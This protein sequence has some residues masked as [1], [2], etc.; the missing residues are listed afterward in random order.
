MID[1]KYAIGFTH[2]ALTDEQKQR[3][4]AKGGQVLHLPVVIC[5]VVPI[6]HVKELKDKPPLKFTG[7]VLAD[8]FRGKIDTWND[9]ALK[10]LNEGIDLPDRKITVVHR[11]DSSGT[12][13]IFTDYLC[14]ES[15]AWRKEVGPPSNKVKWPVGQ[16]KNRN[17]GVAD[18]IYRTEGTIGYVDL[19]LAG[20]GNLQYG[21][22]QNKD[23]SA[24]IH[25]EAD[26]MTAALKGQLGDIPEDLTFRL[27]NQQGK[28]AYPICGC[29]W[30]VCYQAQP[31][32]NQ[33]MVVDFLNW[34]THD[35]QRFAED[36]SYAPLPEELVKR[37]DE[38]LK[39]ITAIQ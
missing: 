21:A 35:V 39:T 7:E 6:Y 34:I 17:H 36:M 30:A 1:G 9:P 33:K 12:T 32:S 28:G 29:V 5:A 25:A 14:G 4:Q 22:V 13:F 8:M 23:R 24:F 10:K 31:A 15:E 38:K 11:E 3:A 20:Y 26:N 19:L 37:V 18:H 27:T 16:G 2:A